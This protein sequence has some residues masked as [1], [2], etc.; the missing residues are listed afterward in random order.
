MG[1]DGEVF[2]WRSQRTPTQWQGHNI[3][4]VKPRTNERIVQ[5]NALVECSYS[6]IWPYSCSPKGGIEVQSQIMLSIPCA[7]YLESVG[8]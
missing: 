2:L 7:F 4:R 3:A 1:K 5:F 8:F 6:F